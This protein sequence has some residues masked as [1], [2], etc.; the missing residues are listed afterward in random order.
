MQGGLQ[1]ASAD[2]YEQGRGGGGDTSFFG[3]ADQATQWQAMRAR[4]RQRRAVNAVDAA[5]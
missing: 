1:D 4:A 3:T 5:S 2:A